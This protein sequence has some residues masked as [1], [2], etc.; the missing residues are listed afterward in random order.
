MAH[1]LL[2]ALGMFGGNDHVSPDFDSIMEASSDTYLL[3]QDSPQPLSLLYPAD[4]EA[5]RILYG[6]LNND[7]SPTEFGTWESTSWQ[8]HGNGQH[9]GF[10]VALRNGYAEPW[11]YGYLP[12]FNLADNPNLT[13]TA[14]WEGHL[15][16]FTPSVEAV[17]GNARLGVDLPTL[18]GDLDFSN[19]ES[20]AANAPP[21]DVGTGQQWDGGTLS[22]DVQVR[23]NT[24]IQT[25]G[26]EGIITGAFFGSEHE[27]MGGTLE[28][29]D[30]TA[31]FGGKR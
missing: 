12:D 19:L 9:V 20:W 25:G 6:R 27:G 28:R 22:Y 4:R 17:A 23:G 26:D 1:E 31:A 29:N 7:D 5:L 14:T 13:G 11:A 10:G 18:D 24:F 15:L 30:L 8:I 2:H 3:A 21:G 16:G